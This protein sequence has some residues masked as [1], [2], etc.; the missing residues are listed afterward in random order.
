[1]NIL[2]HYNSAKKMLDRGIRE[3]ESN[4]EGSAINFFVAASSAVRELTDHTWQLKCNKALAAKPPK[5][6]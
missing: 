1:M 4:H 6:R 2:D 5:K 3:V